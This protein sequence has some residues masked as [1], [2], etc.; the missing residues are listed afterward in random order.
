MT[1]MKRPKRGPVQGSI[2]VF[3]PHGDLRL[4]I[5]ADGTVFQVCS[6][7][8]ARSSPV[9]EAMLYGPFAEGK[10]RQ[11]AAGN[12]WEVTLPE[13]TAEGFCIPL[14]AAHCKLTTIPPILDR[15]TLFAVVAVCDKYVMVECLAP[16]WRGWIEALPDRYPD[17]QV[18]IQE[19]LISHRFG[20]QENYQAVLLM[21]LTFLGRDT[22]SGRIS[23]GKRGEYDLSQDIHLDH[24][25]IFPQ[26]ELAHRTLFSAV[27]KRIREAMEKLTNPDSYHLLDG[28]WQ[29]LCDCAMLGALHRTAALMEVEA[30]FKPGQ[31]GLGSHTSTCLADVIIQ[32]ENM[33][34]SVIAES[35]MSERQGGAHRDC[36]PWTPFTLDDIFTEHRVKD[37]V[38]FNETV[39]FKARGESWTNSRSVYD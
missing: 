15:D 28:H 29:R 7:A 23:V 8:L 11:S 35:G 38:P 5:G 10:D 2:E 25:G 27:G 26:L 12:H 33:R 34:R 1:P 17:P 30:W 13:D 32:L 9:W 14:L 21:L 20:D 16:F 37:L 39:V 36:T 31:E 18:L 4:V 22:A 24:L 3:D 19:L 6:R